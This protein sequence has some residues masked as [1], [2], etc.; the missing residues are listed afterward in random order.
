MGLGA[1]SGF[2]VGRGK[3]GDGVGGGS[4]AGEETG[5][6]AS[7][8]PFTFPTSPNQAGRG[9]SSIGLSPRAGRKGP[10]RG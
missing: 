2:G 3:P 9:R 6:G 4:G 7:F 1:T 8:P 5:D 10:S